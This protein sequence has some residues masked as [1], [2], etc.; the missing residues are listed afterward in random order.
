MTMFIVF[1]TL[2]LILN[3]I[4][5]LFY[6]QCYTDYDL[7]SHVKT[8]LSGHNN[9]HQHNHYHNHNKQRYQY[10]YN[11]DDINESNNTKHTTFPITEDLNQHN[12]NTNNLLK[13]DYNINRKDF[14]NLCPI[15]LYHVGANLQPINE[16]GTREYTST[17]ITRKTLQ[18]FAGSYNSTS[19]NIYEND[20]F[21]GKLQ[22]FSKDLNKS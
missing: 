13:H 20:I 5:T 17:C 14:M 19:I 8:S 1:F 22:C 11:H 3:L 16:N 2:P 4:Y 9:Q 21:Y 18:K 7:V 10:H 12:N 15:L 6:S